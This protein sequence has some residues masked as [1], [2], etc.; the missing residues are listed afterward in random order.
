MNNSWLGKFIFVAYLFAAGTASALDADKSITQYVIDN[1]DTQDGLPHNVVRAITQTDDGY[2]WV[3]T[4]SG[5]A[6]FDGKNFAVIDTS[7]TNELTTED[8]R[9]VFQQSNGD[10]WLATYGG[11][12]VR[13]RDGKHT[14]FTTS[15]GLGDDIVRCVYEDSA[16][17]LWFCTA[18]GLTR[19]AD[20]TFTTYTTEDGLLNNLVYDVF[21]DQKGNIWA[22]VL[23]GVSRFSNGQFE[24]FRAGR[25][26]PGNLS[27]V[28]GFAQ[29]PEGGIWMASYGG[30]LLHFRNGKIT[31]LTREDGLADKRLSNITMDSSGNL[32]V[33]T[34]DKGVQRYRDGRFEQLT[35][36]TGLHSNLPFDVF[37]D[38]QH[39]IWIGTAGGGL[40]RL[41]AGSFTT[42]SSAEGLPDPKVFA[43]LGE[44]KGPIW[45]G[46]EGGGLHRLQDGEID[47]FTTEDGLSNNN[48]ISLSQTRN[49]DLWVGTF[50][51]GLNRF[52][53]GRFRTWTDE[54]GLPGNQIFAMEPGNQNGLWIGTVDGLSHMEDGDF[55][56]YTTADGLAKNDVRALLRDRDGVLWVG[57]NGGGL[58]RFD[59]ERFQTFTQKD[60]LG[61]NLVY[62]LFEDSTGTL[63]IGAK[64]GGLSRLQDGR[65][66]TFTTE[67][68]LW[69]DSIYAIAQDDS[70][71]LWLSCPKGVFRITRSELD[72]V[73]TGESEELNVSTFDRSDGLRSG[74]T[75]GGSQPAVWHS[76]DDRLWFAT[77]DGLASVHPDDIQKS[78]SSP[79]I[80][81]EQLIVNGEPVT[82]GNDPVLPPD[83]RNIEIHYTAIEL[84][85]PDDL[86]FRYRLLGLEDDWTNAGGRRIAYYSHIPPGDYRFQVQAATGR[87][88]WTNQTGELRFSLEPRFHQTTWFLALVGLA[89][90]ALGASL[91]A[92]RVRGLRARERQLSLL[93]GQRTKELAEA[94]ERFEQLSKT[95]P[96]TGLPNRRYF[97]ERLLG[98]WDRAL[99]S[100]HQLGAIMV[101]IDRFKDFNDTNGH[102][103]G[104]QC[105]QQVGNA[106]QNALTRGG[107]I[108]ARYGGDEFVVLLPETNVD[109][110]KTVAER[111]RQVITALAITWP[112]ED[113]KS[114]V[115]ASAG[116]AVTTPR[117]GESSQHFLNIADQALYR[118]KTEGR[119]RV[120]VGTP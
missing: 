82:D 3:G 95:D 111:I 20:E 68:G 114:F 89:L 56:T 34:Y 31:A 74:H 102:Y 44:P 64:G 51:G 92:L 116:A 81:L 33:S 4:Q 63:W 103:A 48:V 67:D 17:A 98:E 88:S 93:V 59:G 58:N 6:R 43:V 90:V 50:G 1:W 96:L 110:T 23:G 100:G 36:E 21:E 86:Q 25:E 113:G 42:F 115:T 22:G 5:V 72:A 8:I 16:G 76:P 24:N 109:G 85:R 75:V 29:H 71:A 26:L 53:D 2:L 78:N 52:R 119:N 79:P 84:T 9:D 120:D 46:T 14:R 28:H 11:G 104:D 107:D 32:W 94:K 15:D 54:D 10:L 55:T 65:I 83:S 112:G 117:E 80:H 12:V 41:K 87:G 38:D 73:I 66:T 61:S 57:T 97:E 99:R 45:F 13:M 18:S 39:N 30:G 60:G 108:V 105:L 101:D 49:K 40:H 35:T 91:Y 27:F 118:A 37:E 77:F 62:S 70:G 106:I 47:T 69:H 7:N 19:L